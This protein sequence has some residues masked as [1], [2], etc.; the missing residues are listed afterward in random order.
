MKRR[1]QAKDCGR[2]AAARGFTLMELLVVISIIAILV[3]LTL[4]VGARVS[5]SGKARVTENAI[6]VLDTAAMAFEASQ[7]QVPPAVVR[8]TD[9]NDPDN[10]ALQ[11]VAD[12]TIN[13]TDEL[14]N[15]VGAFMFQADRVPEVAPTF[16]Q[17]D[18]KLVKRYSP[19]PLGAWNGAQ[20]ELPTVMDGWGRAIRYVHPTF[21]GLV[22]GPN[23]P[24]GVVTLG[25]AGSDVNLDVA[26]ANP[27]GLV[28]GTYNFVTSIRRNN[29]VQSESESPDSDGGLC[30]GNK[31]YFYSTGPDG[32]AG[33]LVDN[34]GKVLEDYNEDNI[35]LVVPTFQKAN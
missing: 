3:S 30:T 32:K 18:P 26:G 5:A 28:S 35:Y 8:W 22:H 7:D 34:S 6:K 27:F 21:D 13:G 25:G 1:S 15:S 20:P 14:I 17:L 2:V 12:A 24:G 31:P 23:Y 4:A 9:P 33:Y 29:T 10:T 16:R 19:A 11:P